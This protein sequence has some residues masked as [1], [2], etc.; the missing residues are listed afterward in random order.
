MGIL[1]FLKKDKQKEGNT[2]G[3]SDLMGF[4]T[5][6]NGIDFN[7]T[8][9][10]LGMLSSYGYNGDISLFSSIEIKP[11][12]LLE[13]SREQVIY[14]AKDAIYKLLTKKGYGF[15]GGKNSSK[16][17]K[18]TLDSYGYKEIL[19]IL[20]EGLIGSGGG[21]VLL[22]IRKINGKPKIVCEPFYYNGL[23]R[24]L[25]DTD[26]VTNQIINYKIVDSSRLTILDLDPRDVI[27]AKYS[28]DGN[29]YFGTNPTII[30]SRYYFVKKAIMAMLQTRAINLKKDKVFASPESNFMIKVMESNKEAGF[31][32][33]WDIFKSLIEKQTGFIFSKIPLDFKKMYQ[34]ID[35]GK[36]LETLKYL[37]EVMAGA[38][39]ASLSIQGRTEGVNYSNSEQ[40]TDNLQNITVEPI[41]VMFENI[42]TDLIK[43]IIPSYDKYKNKFYFGKELDEEDLAQYELKTS[44][45]KTQA[46]I[47]A[48]LASNPNYTLDL[49]TMEIIKATD[50]PKVSN[51]KILDTEENTD[52]TQP[53]QTTRSITRL[54]YVKEFENSPEY[55]AVLNRIEKVYQDMINKGVKL[56]TA[57]NKQGWINLGND[58]KTVIE[59]LYQDIYNENFD[60]SWF[61]PFI[62]VSLFGYGEI[63]NYDG[64]IKDRLSNIFDSSYEGMVTKTFEQTELENLTQE[65]KD[66]LVKTQSQNT[67]DG[68]GI[69]LL[70]GAFAINA[71]LKKKE[72]VG[73]I[74]MRDNKVRKEHKPNDGKFW[75]RLSR[76]D[77]SRDYNCR[78]RYFYGSKADMIR[79]GFTQF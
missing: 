14:S 65:E 69:G 25:V 29:S 58:L 70:Q 2:R 4:D 45:A 67:M 77:F 16:L 54:D 56:E 28:I 17:L 21:N 68:F 48:I 50:Q 5:N 59:Y 18:D 71:I 35:E 20:Y 42:T 52:L 34:T 32:N 64:I 73:V 57:L 53:N 44:R 23:E 8:W 37:D 6:N 39:L 49:D 55:L 47:L 63:A 62:T 22:F 38:F 19:P 40:N 13:T 75:L 60:D 10:N 3:L 9:G 15:I 46:E 72:Y 26:K 78:C 36:H 33:K 12:Y 74:I 7:N 31:F 41:K 1:D 79:L 43:L 51:P 27:H 76:K 24:V 61:L 30:A 11:E 66:N